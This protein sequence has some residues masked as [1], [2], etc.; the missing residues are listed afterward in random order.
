MF[1]KMHAKDSIHY[2]KVYQDSILTI[3][4]IKGI[5]SFMSIEESMSRHINFEE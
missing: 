1:I 3:N 4:G 2:R 5:E